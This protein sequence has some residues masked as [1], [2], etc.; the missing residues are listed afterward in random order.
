MYIVAAFYDPLP[1][2]TDT[3][4]ETGLMDRTSHYFYRTILDKTDCTSCIGGF[5]PK[6]FGAFTFGWI[7]VFLCLKNGISTTGKIA[8]FTVVAPYVLLTILL[9]K[10]LMLPGSKEG[11]YYI[12][13]P[14]M[15]KLLNSKIWSEAINQAFLQYSIGQGAMVIFSSFRKTKKK[16]YKGAFFICMMNALSS[17][18]ASLVV[19]GYLG[20]YT[21]LN[22]MKFEDLPISGVDLMF[23]TYPVIF[24][25]MEWPN[26]WL[27]FFFTTMIF[28]GIDSQFGMVECA[29]FFV[30]DL[31]LQIKRSGDKP[32]IKIRGSLA[33]GLV[34]FSQFLLGLPLC[35]QGG[36]HIFNVYDDYAFRIPATVTNFANVLLFVKLSDMDVMV[37][38]MCKI[39]GEKKA[40]L[41]MCMLRYITIW[42]FITCFI[43]SLVDTWDRVIYKHAVWQNV[44]GH[45]MAFLGIFIILYF[46]IRYRKDI[47]VRNPYIQDLELELEIDD[48]RMSEKKQLRLDKKNKKND[49]KE[50]SENLP[51][52]NTVGG[53][54][55]DQHK[56][57]IGKMGNKE[58]IENLECMEGKLFF[59]FEKLENVGM[60]NNEIGMGN[61]GI[62][63][64]G[65]PQEEQQ[66]NCSPEKSNNEINTD[67]KKNDG[68]NKDK[69]IVLDTL[70]DKD[71]FELDAENEKRY[72]QLDNTLA[73]G[74]FES[75]ND[76]DL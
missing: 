61:I 29:S 66:K 14:E 30:E 7:L 22:N 31:Q 3:E 59:V 51:L 21:E 63:M 20:F 26:F 53:N 19:F 71:S 12:F 43:V 48:Q 39:S 2:Q 1:W 5:N 58:H 56:V 6:V 33:K 16:V 9:V 62:E 35:S 76:N 55:G 44:F 68:E 38:A 27:G 67:K 40:K 73:K 52:G 50:Q 11:I 10:V 18:F 42:I 60:E 24:S 41:S 57:E 23:V 65:F 46:H 28:I 4:S 17:I 72:R 25:T 64:V 74:S 49:K 36:L 45:F 15:K 47:T 70:P 8:L 37:D 13:Y 34:C 32:P 69:H 75:N 54:I